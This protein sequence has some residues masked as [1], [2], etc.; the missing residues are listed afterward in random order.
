MA[1]C[2]WCDSEQKEL[3]W[4]KASWKT[5]VPKRLFCTKNL[6]VFS[7]TSR[8]FNSSCFF[9]FPPTEERSNQ[10]WP[11]CWTCHSFR[12]LPA[13]KNVAFNQRYWRVTQIVNICEMS[14]LYLR[15]TDNLG[16]RRE[17]TALLNFFCIISRTSPDPVSTSPRCHH[18]Y[19][20]SDTFVKF[21]S[22]SHF[23]KS[24]RLWKIPESLNRHC[25][26]FPVLYFTLPKEL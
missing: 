21:T 26:C 15:I 8:K 10:H 5:R 4:W 14:E 17:A 12:D 9:F 20:A 2:T 3:S 1:H 7:M 11:L 19:A 23:C 13:V 18:T 22:K 24:E 25:K 16:R 6:S